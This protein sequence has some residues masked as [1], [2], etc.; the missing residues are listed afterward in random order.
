MHGNSTRRLVVASG[1]D[2]GVGH[3][4][5]HAL[6]A[7]VNPLDLGNAL[8]CVNP[9]RGDRLPLHDRSK[10]LVHSMLVLAGAGENFSVVEHVRPQLDLFDSTPAD[11]TVFRTFHEISCETKE[12]TGPHYKGGWGF[13]PMFC[14]ADATGGPFRACCVWVMPEPTGSLTT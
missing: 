9:P 10:V 6:G 11:S 1:G 13:H 2:R 7:F 14:F 12:G 5:L 8:S 3:F 4:G